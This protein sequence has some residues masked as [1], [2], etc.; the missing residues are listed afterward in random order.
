MTDK[1][2]QEEMLKLDIKSVEEV[3]SESSDSEE[4]DKK[5]LPSPLHSSKIAYKTVANRFLQKKN[6]QT[7]TRVDSLDIFDRKSKIDP[8]ALLEKKERKHVEETILELQ[9][10]THLSKLEVADLHN[11]YFSKVQ[12]GK[13]TKDVFREALGE[14]L[15]VDLGANEEVL[16]RYYA[17]FDNDENGSIDFR[18]FVSGISVLLKGTLKE[19]A[20]FIFSVYD[21]DGSGYIEKSEM[22]HLLGSLFHKGTKLLNDILLSIQKK[23]IVFDHNKIE[24]QDIELIVDA[25]FEEADQNNDKK[26]S[27][28]EFTKWLETQ[29]H[30]V[31]WLSPGIVIEK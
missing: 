8:K 18:E 6:N 15:N 21:E 30:I 14:L 22:I 9:Q 29:P 17:L 24:K 5:A 26:L 23:E 4:E 25:C 3:N 7:L 28:E 11:K 27:K 13:M 2:T 20:E 10:N 12:N 1:V 31:S 16:Q 19:K